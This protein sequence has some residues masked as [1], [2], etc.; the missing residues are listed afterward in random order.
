MVG[1][2]TLN[3]LLT[4]YDRWLSGWSFVLG[5]YCDLR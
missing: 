1:N 2:F 3:N 4:Y 5:L